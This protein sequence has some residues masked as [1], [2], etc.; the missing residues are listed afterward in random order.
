MR[1]IPAVASY[2]GLQ[3]QVR[4]ALTDEHLMLLQQVAMQPLAVAEAPPNVAAELIEM[5]VLQVVEGQ[6]HLSTAVFLEDDIQRVGAL[7]TELGKELAKRV[8]AVGS[9]L[10]SASP[11]IR[12]FLGGIIGAAQGPSQLLRSTGQ[13]IRWQDYTGK[14]AK[15]KVDFDQDCPAFA[16]FGQELQVKTVLRG[17][18]YTAVFIGPGGLTFPRFINAGCSAEHQEY[19]RELLRYLTDSYGQLLAGELKSESL[20]RTAELVGVFQDGKPRP[21][22]VTEALFESY[23]AVVSR[24]A[25]ASCEVYARNLERIFAV[26]RTTT[27]GR[28]GVPPENMLM[29]FGRYCRKALAHELYSA[30]FFTDQVPQTG[31]ITVFY[32]NTIAAL[33]AYLR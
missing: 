11:E 24:I 33:D 4:A 17:Q 1:L 28:Q 31:V 30:G 32:E 2:L 3:G 16:S 29:H 10:Q 5:H 12:N 14:Y 8:M 20:A 27:S 25:S 6:L 22:L 15:T 23:Q 26:L 19:R 21:I 13:G 7:A 18:Q 9:E